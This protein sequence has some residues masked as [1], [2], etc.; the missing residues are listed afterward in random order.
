MSIRLAIGI[1]PG[2]YGAVALVSREG[3][4]LPQALG[5]W[6][7]W[8]SWPRL[9]CQRARAAV[10]EAGKAA[11]VL[12]VG[13]PIVWQE[14][15]IAK[16]RGGRISGQSWFGLGRYCGALLGIYW[17]TWGEFPTEVHNAAWRQQFN[18][19]PKS[20]RDKGRHRIGE[21][22]RWISGSR[23]MI[24]AVRESCQVDAAEAFLVAGAAVMSKENR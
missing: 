19:R 24:L 8:G 20:K 3:Q 18:L 21:A 10:Y 7:I 2:S 22:A 9:W 17:S 23:P 5:V 4:N 11:E 15:Q 12:G 6:A 16:S 1:D 14:D 13:K